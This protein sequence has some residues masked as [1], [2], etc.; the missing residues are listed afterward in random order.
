M[1][2]ILRFKSSFVLGVLIIL[3]AFRGS[4]AHTQQAI[5]KKAMGMENIFSTKGKNVDQEFFDGVPTAAAGTSKSSKKLGGR[6]MLLDADNEKEVK[7]KHGNTQLKDEEVKSAAKISGA[8]HSS[9]GKCDDEQ[10]G[11]KGDE[12]MNVL[13]CNKLMTTNDR[14]LTPVKVNVGG[15]ISFSADY[16]IPIPHPPKNN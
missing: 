4:I 6:K 1:M 7:M 8:K 10:K 2:L 3:L 9:I 16:H 12:L 13:D 15:I 11:N 14:S 5:E